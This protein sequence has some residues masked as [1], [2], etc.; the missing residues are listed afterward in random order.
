MPEVPSW[1]PCWDPS[2]YKQQ[3][4]FPVD[5]P[6]EVQAGSNPLPLETATSNTEN[7]AGEGYQTLI[8]FNGNCVRPG[9]EGWE[10]PWE[11][12]GYSQR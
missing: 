8:P 7:N 2:E 9:D 3:P 1:D 6:P 10:S 4:L 12:T 5:E 11:E